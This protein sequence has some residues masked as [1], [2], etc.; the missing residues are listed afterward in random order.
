MLS[1]EPVALEELAELGDMIWGEK[2]DILQKRRQRDLKHRFARE[3]KR[4][5]VPRVLQL[6]C[7]LNQN[8]NGKAEDRF[9]RETNGNTEG[10]ARVYQD[11]RAL[12]HTG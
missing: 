7:D 11:D 1:R 3:T 5:S 9:H 12:Q 2:F 8:V 4:Q 10:Q 6:G